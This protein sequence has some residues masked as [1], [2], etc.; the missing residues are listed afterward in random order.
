MVDVIY[1]SLAEDMAN[2]NV[3]LGSDS[4]KLMLVTSAYAPNSDTH[5][6][7]SDVTNEI[8]GGGYTAGGNALAGV[9]VT[10]DTANDRLVFD[11][12]DVVFTAL[13]NT[14]RGAVLYKDTGVAANDNLV[15]Y[16]DFTSDQTGTGGDVTIQFN[17][18]GIIR[19]QNNNP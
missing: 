12:N 14:F 13:T 3:V 8:S 11:A 9:T 15:M 19:F 1:N 7:R 5:T 16:F 10:N 18:N 17:A 4:F 2:G 6:K